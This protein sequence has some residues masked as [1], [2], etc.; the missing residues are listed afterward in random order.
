MGGLEGRRVAEAQSFVLHHSCGSGE[1]FERAAPR[2]DSRPADARLDRFA[3]ADRSAKSGE[4]PQESCLRC[5]TS[6]GQR[7]HFEGSSV[8]EEMGGRGFSSRGA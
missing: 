3:N 7:K 2:R 5:P 8:V 1:G 6:A 4:V